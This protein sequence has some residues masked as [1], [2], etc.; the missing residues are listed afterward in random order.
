MRQ[1]LEV[2]LETSS[3]PAVAVLKELSGP[4]VLRLGGPLARAISLIRP[5]FDNARKD[6]ASITDSVLG[7]FSHLDDV[8]L[9][10]VQTGLLQGMVVR[11]A[12]GREDNHPNVDD[13]FDAGQSNQY[14]ALLF[15][16]LKL[17][18]AHVF[19]QALANTRAQNGSVSTQP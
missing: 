19:L 15:A 14:L 16:A 5:A 3:G 8:A 1:T 13:M 17:S 7:A 6:G 12:D 4:A 11:Y 10:R 2:P 9:Q 18:Y